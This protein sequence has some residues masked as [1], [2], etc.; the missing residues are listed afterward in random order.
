MARTTDQP[1]AAIRPK[2]AKTQHDT[3]PSGS[4]EGPDHQSENGQLGDTTD[5]R[6]NLTAVRNEQGG[7]RDDTRENPDER[8][9]RGRGDDR[10]VGENRSERMPRDGDTEQGSWREQRPTPSAGLDAFAP[11]LEAWKQV[12]KSWSELTDSMV[13]AQQ[14]AFASMIGAANMTVKNIKDAEVGERRDA[15]PAFSAS[16]TTVSKLDRVERDR[17]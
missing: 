7:E 9:N 13:K 4:F 10:E 15:E 8:G 16:R 5:R 14:D 1:S 12:F 2:T 3:S 11:V 6:K 17:R